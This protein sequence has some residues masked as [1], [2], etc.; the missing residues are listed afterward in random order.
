MSL[1][2]SKRRVLGDGIRDQSDGSP[3]SPL[4][5]SAS[6]RSSRPDARY[7]ARPRT[8]TLVFNW[9][10][11]STM[12]PEI[13][14]PRTSCPSSAAG[15]NSGCWHEPYRASRHPH[16]LRERGRFPELLRRK[17]YCRVDDSHRCIGTSRVKSDISKRV[18]ENV[19]ESED[20]AEQA[21]VKTVAVLI[22]IS[23]IPHHV[24]EEVEPGQAR[25][26]RVDQN[27]CCW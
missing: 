9:A 27:S 14:T 20:V 15:Q 7:T 23:D 24:T 21:L 8:R 2:G 5:S 3:A 13:K 19:L 6:I 16:P 4:I 18:V 1:E 11:A 10:A 22:V 26:G 17:K 12:L 25:V